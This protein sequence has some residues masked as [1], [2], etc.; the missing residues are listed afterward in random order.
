[1]DPDNRRPVDFGLRERL[2]ADLDTAV[3]ADPLRGPGADALLA[4]VEIG[5]PKLWVMRQALALRGRRAEA[6]VPDAP[7]R[8]LLGSGQAADHVVAFTRAERVATV[9]PRLPL[10]LARGRIGA[11]LVAPATRW[12]DT[13]IELPPGRWRDVLTGDRHRVAATS[14]GLRV[15]RVL[16]RFPVAL[17]ER[18]E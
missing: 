17:L 13:R 10:R 15:A 16:G 6:F 18:D 2:L 8:A 11:R 14:S 5:L 12:G 7:Y 9:T 1:V 3:E 4:E